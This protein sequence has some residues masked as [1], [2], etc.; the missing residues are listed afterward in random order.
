MALGANPRLILRMVLLQGVR[1]VVVGAAAGVVAALLAT[2]YIESQLFGISRADPMTM[3]SAIM[4]LIVIATLACLI[5]A[6]RALRVEP[7]SALRA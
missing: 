1:L 5:P 4:L 6:R 2:K 7:T 3:L